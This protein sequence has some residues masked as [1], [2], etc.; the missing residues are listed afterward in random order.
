MN[1]NLAYLLTG[2]LPFAIPLCA[3]AA[4]LQLNLPVVTQQHSEWCW[5]ADASAILQY[6]GIQQ[7]QC[8]IANWVYGIS[9]A[10]GNYPFNWNNNANS[11]NAMTGSTGI[12]GIV[13]NL[14]GRHWYYYSQ[15]VSYSTASN[16]I[17]HGNPVV[18]LWEWQGGGGHFVVLDGY[19]DNGHML[20]FM[21]PWP[22]EGAG[23]GSYTWIAHGTGDMGTHA[24]AESLITY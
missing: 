15:A 20:Y 6:R 11:P 5:D 16:A 2:S 12:S 4:T 24:W 7:S 10:C 13:W 14:G 21:N 3:C 1:K 9:Y 22:G 8:A 17:N 18:I 23:Y 19:D